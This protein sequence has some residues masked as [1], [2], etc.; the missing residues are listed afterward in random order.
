MMRTCRSLK[1][2]HDCTAN[3]I[4]SGTGCNIASPQFALMQNDRT[5]TD[6]LAL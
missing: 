6:H 3:A 2:P 4:A 1:L 5:D